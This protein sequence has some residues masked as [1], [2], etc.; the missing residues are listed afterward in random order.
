MRKNGGKI[1]PETEFKPGQSGNP[2]GRPKGVPN[3]KTRMAR[4]LELSINGKNPITKEDELFTVA[5]LMDLQVISKAI[6]G[7]LQAWEKI[8]DR[9]EGK[10]KQTTEHSGEIKQNINL[11]SLSL[12]EK[13]K[14]LELLQK[15]DL[16]ED[17]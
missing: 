4:F 3:A 10:A 14:A 6:K 2:K 1:S 13:R 16:K 15:A 7:D 11:D 9:L 5:E 12:D 8:N 17:E